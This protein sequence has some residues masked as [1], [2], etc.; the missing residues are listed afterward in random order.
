MGNNRRNMAVALIVTLT[1]IG[2]TADPKPV[3]SLVFDQAAQAGGVSDD[4]RARTIA[5]VEAWQSLDVGFADKDDLSTSFCPDDWY[6]T[7]D[8]LPCY[9][10]IHVTYSPTAEL[11]GDGLTN[12]RHIYLA[13]EISGDQLTEAAAHGIGHVLWNSSYHLADDAVGIMSNPASSLLPTDADR[14][15]VAEHALGWQ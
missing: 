10:Q 4:I 2:C 9:M 1:L 14:A 13:L 7:P 6:A 8:A 3:V 11:G 5:G 15:Y 12:W